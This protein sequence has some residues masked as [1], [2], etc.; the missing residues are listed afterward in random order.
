MLLGA[1]LAT[2]AAG[3]LPGAD[4]GDRLRHAD[5]RRGFRVGRGADQRHRRLRR[6]ARAE[7]PADADLRRR[8]RARPNVGESTQAPALGAAMFGAVAA[9]RG[10]RLRLDHRRDGADGPAQK[11][12]Y[13][14]NPAHKPVYDELFAEY[15]TLHDYFGRGGNDVMKRLKDPGGPWLRRASL[16]AGTPAAETPF[17]ARSGAAARRESRPRSG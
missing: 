4:R 13:V 6:T 2:Q 15:R 11:T 8:D 7:P 14:P 17:I 12:Q 10:G 1:T 9:G 5:D 16:S 3:D